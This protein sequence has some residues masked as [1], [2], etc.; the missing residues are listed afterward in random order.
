MTYIPDPYTSKIDDEVVDGLYGVNNS[1]A[2]KVHELEKH[3]HNWERWIGLAASPSGTQHRFDIDSMTPFQ[4]DAGDDTWGD[5]LQIVGSDD[6]PIS[7]GMV[8]RD[9]HRFLI[10][11]VE[12]DTTIT[13]VQIAGGDDADAAVAAGNYTEFMFV[14]LKNS[15]Q[16][17]VTIMTGRA[18]SA[19]KGWARCWVNGQDTGTVDFF[20]GI[21]EYP[22]V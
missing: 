18:A 2:Y 5:W 3:F 6:F 20:L 16:I 4:M 9:A 7:D 10:S 14:P 8:K 15:S 21:H 17:P 1:L 11:D 22:G 12:R 19:V 13:R